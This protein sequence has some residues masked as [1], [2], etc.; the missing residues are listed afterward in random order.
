MHDER[1]HPVPI[2]SGIGLT[3]KLHMSVQ[4]KQFIVLQDTWVPLQLLGFVLLVLKG[5]IGLFAILFS[6][7]F[8]K[9]MHL[10]YLVYVLQLISAA[11]LK[12]DSQLKR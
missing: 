9:K 5:K 3:I 12:P 7:F 1:I 4:R 8:L 2:Q 6:I 10:F 11:K